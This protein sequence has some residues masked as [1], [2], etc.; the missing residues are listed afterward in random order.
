MNIYLPWAT[1]KS[2]AI[3]KSQ[4]RFEDRD[5]FYKISYNDSFGRFESTIA[6][7][8]T[9]DIADFDA[10]YLTYANTP[11]IGQ[12]PFSDP[13]GFRA[14]F[15]G[16]SGTMVNSSTSNLDLVLAEERW[17]DGVELMQVGAEK[18]DTVSFQVVHPT[19]GVVDTFGENW[20]VESTDGKQ[21]PVVLSYPAKLAAGLTIRAAYTSVGVVDVWLGLNLRLHVKTI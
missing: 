6:K 20:N 8:E 19:Y 3:N 11:A 9:A 1:F 21:N 7:T 16:I 10:N 2:K 14:R 5:D 17:I 18:G 12:T 4:I 15:K 13:S